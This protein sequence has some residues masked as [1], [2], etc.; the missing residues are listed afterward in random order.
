MVPNFTFLDLNDLLGLRYIQQYIFNLERQ[1]NISFL[2]K[3]SKTCN[4]F[5][6]YWNPSTY[7]SYRLQ[8][9]IIHPYF[10]S[11]TLTK[12]YRIYY[13]YLFFRSIS[14]KLVKQVRSHKQQSSEKEFQLLCLR[15]KLYQIIYRNNFQLKCKQRY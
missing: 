6:L 9:C 3:L 15:N 14:L 12:Y 13:K 4:S 7:N 1:I 10:F 11:Q 2:L 5:A 8:K